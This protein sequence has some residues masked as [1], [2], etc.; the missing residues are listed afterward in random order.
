M[1]RVMPSHHRQQ[2]PR[3]ATRDSMQLNQDERQQQVSPTPIVQNLH[4]LKE[5][6]IQLPD[7][8]LPNEPVDSSPR[9]SDREDEIESRRKSEQ[10]VFKVK[11]TEPS[12]QFYYQPPT[13]I[14]QEYVYQTPK[15]DP[16]YMMRNTFIPVHHQPEKPKPPPPRVAPKPAF[17]KKV[18]QNHTFVAHQPPVLP[19]KREAVY[20]RPPEDVIYQHPPRFP[21]EPPLDQKSQPQQGFKNYDDYLSKAD[22]LY[23]AQQPEN[24]PEQIARIP[25]KDAPDDSA[26]QQPEVYPQSKPPTPPPLPPAASTPSSTFTSRGNAS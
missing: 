10:P 6:D 19:S 8:E 9:K 14:Q 1:N 4:F 13:V 20:Q 3:D 12:P 22:I 15:E 21:A 26:E 7:T 11:N 18:Y 2:Q 24:P 17:Q 5:S 16:T 25:L 23:P